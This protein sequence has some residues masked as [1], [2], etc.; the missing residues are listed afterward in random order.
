MILVTG[1]TGLVGLHIIR[2]LTQQGNSL[3]ALYHVRKPE[4]LA[5]SIEHLI[6]WVQADI[7]DITSLEFAFEGVTHV[8]HCAAIVSYDKRMVDY[9]RHVNIQ[10]TANV[11]DMCILVGVKK[12]VHVSSI[13]TMGNADM[14]H[15][16]ISEKTVWKKE[17]A[18]SAY[19]VSKYEAELEVYR[20]MAEGLPAVI[21]NPAIILGE[22][23]WR[24][25]SAN[26][27]DVVYR[28]FPYYTKGATAWVDVYDVIRAMVLI[29]DSPV[30]HERFILAGYNRTFRDVFTDMAHAMHRKPPHILAK[31]WMIAIVWRWQYIVSKLVGKT[32]TITRETAAS[33]QRVSQYSSDYFLQYFPDFIFTPLTD[34]I[35]RI[36]QQYLINK[37]SESI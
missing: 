3:K 21:I 2:Y 23:D 27:W 33:A 14:P 13:A 30:L 25:S 8:Y 6:T 7:T 18:T 28:E 1:A 16:P 17:E 15:L 19:S 5:G 22:G 31:P 12:L 29:M 20:G 34:T 9:M 35:T 11:V 4:P 24:Y 26:L 36:A 10:G 37:A 32:A